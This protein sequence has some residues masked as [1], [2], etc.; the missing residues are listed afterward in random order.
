MKYLFDIHSLIFFIFL[1]QTFARFK[2]QRQYH[3][4]VRVY[5][6]GERQVVIHDSLRSIFDKEGLHY[7]ETEQLLVLDTASAAVSMGYYASEKE[8]Q[9]LRIFH[10]FPTN[11]ACEAY[12]GTSKT[13]LTN[14]SSYNISS[15]KL[16]E[17]LENTAFVPGLLAFDLLQLYTS[18]DRDAHVM[19]FNCGTG[20]FAY[21]SLLQSYNYWG[22]DTGENVAKTKRTI[23]RALKYFKDNADR[24]REFMEF[25]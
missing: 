8:R 11:H 4:S 18:D 12:L 7:F 19:D 15:K 16:A 22:C 9:G 20:S 5:I 2:G 3:E 6:T 24:S 17:S 1:F 25:A 14:K 13:F 23:D 10:V 21:I